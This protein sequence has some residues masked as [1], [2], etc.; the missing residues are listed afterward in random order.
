MPA[1]TSGRVATT[2][3]PGVPAGRRAAPTRRGH[4]RRSRAAASHQTLRRRRCIRARWRRPTG[5][6]PSE[7]WNR[8]G[9]APCRGRCRRGRR[10]R[11]ARCAPAARRPPSARARCAPAWTGADCPYGGRQGGAGVCGL[12][13]RRHGGRQIGARLISRSWILSSS[14]SSL[15]GR[16]SGESLR[17]G[18]R[19]LRKTRSGH[20]VAPSAGL[21]PEGAVLIRAGGGKI[22][23]DRAAV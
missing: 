13:R 2:R 6:S 22:K 3:G 4:S 18:M 8:T 7:P 20:G 15:A 19:R 21:R 10:H 1:P 17:G 16:S 5:G 23:A 12:L 11:H 9:R 14:A